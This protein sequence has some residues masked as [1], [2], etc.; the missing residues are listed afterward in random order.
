MPHRI[1][2][3]VIAIVVAGVSGAVALWAGRPSD[4]PGGPGQATAG[5]PP[6]E[7]W[8]SVSWFQVAEPDFRGPGGSNLVSAGWG[9]GRLM[10]WGSS[11]VLDPFAVGEVQ[12]RG[13]LWTS[14]DGTSWEAF[15]VRLPGDDQAFHLSLAAG[16]PSGFLVTGQRER[17]D[18]RGRVLASADGRDWVEVERPPADAFAHLVALETGF[19][20]L[21]SGRI[22]GRSG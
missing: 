15:E 19:A 21:G 12:Q 10:G 22:A 4:D 20:L 16:G 9:G 7:A 1:R 18:G 13:V 8:P 3:L 6:V 2:L 17:G 5:F 14:A 11:G